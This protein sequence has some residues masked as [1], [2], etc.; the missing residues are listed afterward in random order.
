MIGVSWFEAQA[1]SNWL[2]QQL[3]AWPWLEPEVEVSLPTE[4]EWEYAARGP[5]SRPYPW[6]ED[7]PRA[8]YCNGERR[9]QSTTPIGIYPKGVSPFGLHDMA[10]NVDEW[11]SDIW[12]SSA[13]KRKVNPKQDSLASP[14]GA[15]R[16]LRG[17]AWS[18]VAVGLRCAYRLGFLAVNRDLFQGFR[19]CLRVRCSSEHGHG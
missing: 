17:G 8:D 11:C 1:F 2:S 5:S 13:Y 16:V 7:K 14:D 19:L 6:G 10:G 18:V 9:I 4:A 12:D 15:V 3:S